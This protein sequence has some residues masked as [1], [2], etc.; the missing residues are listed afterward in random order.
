VIGIRPEL[1]KGSSFVAE[2]ETQALAFRNYKTVV[3]AS[4]D[5]S[6][7]AD[8][9]SCETNSHPKGLAMTLPVGRSGTENPG[10]P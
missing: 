1:L 4:E 5:P 7:I 10:D 8:N 2:H 3:P 6:G 9:P